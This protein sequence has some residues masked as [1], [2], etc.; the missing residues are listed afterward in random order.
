MVILLYVSIIVLAGIIF[1]YKGSNIAYA[2]NIEDSA[3]IDLTSLV[4]GTPSE[5]TG[6]YAK[7]VTIK[8]GSY[9]YRVLTSNTDIYSLLREYKIP[10]EKDERVTCNTKYVMDGSIIKLI[11]TEVVTEIKEIDLPYKVEI[12]KTDKYMQG[13]EYVTQEGV[14]GI[15]TEKYV[16]YFEDGVLIKSE[17]VEE[18]I[19][20]EPT[21]EIVEMGTAT[22][23]LQD[24]QQKGYNCNY[25]YSVVDSGPYTDQEKQWLKYVMY[26]E[27]GCN[28]ESN[29]GTY[30]GLFQWNPKYWKIFYPSDN[31]FD[32]NAQI[33]NTV[34]KIRA[35]VNMSSYWPSCHARYVA[36]YGEF[37]R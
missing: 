18:R 1:L 3:Y 30:K 33:R 35:G 7:F 14:L 19:K 22:Y 20:R 34:Q 15:K 17:L 27:S 36:T 16:N 13:E 5:Y 2:Q 24:I 37:V 28:A 29:K 12:I 32:G 6:N 4:Y 10:V 23:S 11:K 26:C 21:K 8:K 9:L 25:W 31:I